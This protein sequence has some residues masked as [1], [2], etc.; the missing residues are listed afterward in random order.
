MHIMLVLPEENVDAVAATINRN[1]TS[2]FNNNEE[3]MGNLKKLVDEALLEASEGNIYAVVERWE[4][5]DRPDDDLVVAKV[6]WK[7][8][9]V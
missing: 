3:K 7:R 4:M 9:S 2:H 5:D 6:Q 1:A 8:D